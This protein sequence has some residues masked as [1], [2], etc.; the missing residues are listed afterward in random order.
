MQTAQ[1]AATDEGDL[2]L[3][4]ECVSEAADDTA[5]GTQTSGFLPAEPAQVV[6]H[7]TAA[8]VLTAQAELQPNAAQSSTVEAAPSAAAHFPDSF[9]TLGRDSNA[10]LP[11]VVAQHD[12]AAAAAAW[13]IWSACAASTS[14]PAGDSA[15]LDV[16]DAARAFCSAELIT[17]EEMFDLVV[18]LGCAESALIG[19][20]CTA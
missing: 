7:H 18:L 3:A 16:D 15:K 2:S 12:A 19:K 4:S 10:D 9:H 5:A 14:S 13:G 1:A 20:L 17:L 11:A 8:L 6:S